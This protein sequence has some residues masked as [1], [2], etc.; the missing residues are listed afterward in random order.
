MPQGGLP[1]PTGPMGPDG[2]DAL[3]F[4][5]FYRNVIEHNPKTA[6]CSQASVTAR[7]GSG[8]R[9]GVAVSVPLTFQRV[10]YVSR[11]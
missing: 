9:C 8:V 6:D 2:R 3:M 7:A 5:D 10:F 4:P 1:V 11:G